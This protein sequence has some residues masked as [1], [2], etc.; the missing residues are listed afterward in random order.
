MMYR[1][2]VAFKQIFSLFFLRSI[3]CGLLLQVKRRLREIHAYNIEEARQ[4]IK[5]KERISPCWLL[6]GRKTSNCLRDEQSRSDSQCRTQL[7]V[8]H[9]YTARVAT[10]HVQSTCG[11]E[12]TYRTDSMLRKWGTWNLWWKTSRTNTSC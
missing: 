4:R 11:D 10:K 12:N 2:L 1:T 7:I 8:A 5:K 6:E 9:T 3:F